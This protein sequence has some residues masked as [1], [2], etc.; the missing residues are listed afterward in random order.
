VSVAGGMAHA[1]AEAAALG[2]TS[3]Q[4]F[5][6]NQ[7]RWDGR[8]VDA[9]DIRACRA[10]PELMRRALAHASYLV[11]L[12][13]PV[14][15]LWQRSLHAMHD[16]MRRCAALGIPY[17]VVHP[18]AHVGSGEEEGLRRI[19]SALR[20]L[21]GR[22][23]AREV[24]I[25]LEC[26]AGQGSTLGHRFEHLARLVEEGGDRSRLGV[27]IDTC[28][29]LAAGYDARSARGYTE[30]FAELERSV[31]LER[32]RAFHL[33]DSQ[34]PLGGRRD[35]H[36]EIGRGHLGRGFFRRLVQDER[37][38]GLPMVLETPG[39][40]GAYRRGLA[41]LRRFLPPRGV[42][43]SRTRAAPGRGRG[44]PRDRGAGIRASPPGR[45]RRDPA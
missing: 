26:T 9:E 39:G 24:S 35:R 13:S 15:A 33:N 18:G 11:N 45:A 44:L 37:F 17:L 34:V 21:L 25:L 1:L 10:A 12:A 41:L 32:L 31:G 40:M 19:A 5:V 28:H 43:G 42:T 30:V 20:W 8:P 23:D 3:I 27:C 36:E 14:D 29:L 16:E 22:L 6:K 4:V 38:A 7:Q 2:C